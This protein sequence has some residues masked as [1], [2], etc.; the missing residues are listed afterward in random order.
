[1]KTSNLFTAI[2]LILA[3]VVTASLSP[4]QMRSGKLGVGVGGS[5]YLFNPNLKD[6]LLKGGGG[7]SLSYS[8]MEHVGLL[9]SLGGGQLGWKDD[10]GFSNTTTVLSGDL[11][12]SYDVLPHS[13]FNP[14]IFVG[15][16][17]M[18]FDPRSDAGNYLAAT[19]DKIDVTYLGGIG[20]DFFFSEFT[21]LTISGDFVQ[22][23]TDK[24][25][26]QKGGRT[27]PESYSRV[28]L[29]FLYYFFDQDYITRL[30]K[31]LEERYSKK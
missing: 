27:S 21:S 24:L 14:F 11:K 1:M 20:F 22:T 12:V 28:N 5:L 10:F 30:L 4:A 19:A 26:M 8:I 29:E 31:A 9:A 17:G 18:Y 23:N 3:T 6:N 7:A 13:T 25:D 2:A 16:G 15:A